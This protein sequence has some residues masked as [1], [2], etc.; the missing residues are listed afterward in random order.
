[1]DLSHVCYCSPFS[2]DTIWVACNRNQKG[3]PNKCPEARH[4]EGRHSEIWDLV[5]INK[6]GQM[7]PPQIR[8]D[9]LPETSSA[10]INS[11]IDF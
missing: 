11:K 1:M 6:F 10:E 9:F 3:L 7:S 8:G 4:T 5:E 2:G